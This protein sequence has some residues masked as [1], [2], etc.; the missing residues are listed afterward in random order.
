MKIYIIS[1]KQFEKAFENQQWRKVK[2]C[3]QCDF[4]SSW[5]ESLKTHLK[6]H[7]E[8]SNECNECD[9]AISEGGILRRHLKKTKWRTEITNVI[10]HPPRHTI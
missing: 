8:Y 4:V 9:H 3:N 7:S 6:I 1:L 10:M 2:K 5:A